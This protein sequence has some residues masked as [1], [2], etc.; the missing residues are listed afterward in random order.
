MKAIQGKYRMIALT[1]SDDPK[2]QLL[3]WWEPSDSSFRGVVKMGDD[4]WDLR[5]VATDLTFA[6]SLF[7]EIYIT[8]DLKSGVLQFR[9]QWEPKPRV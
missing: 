9:S 4:E 5:T 1:R 3:E 6:K 7:H 2:M 8:G